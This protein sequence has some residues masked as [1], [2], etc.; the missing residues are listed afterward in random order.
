MGTQH[1]GPRFRPYF[2]LRLVP[3]QPSYPSTMGDSINGLVVLISGASS[4]IG[5]NCAMEFAKWGAKLA[6]TGR[7]A[8]RLEASAKRCQDLGL[9]KKNIYTITG[10]VTVKEDVQRIMDSVISHYGKLDVLVNNAGA[11]RARN[12]DTCEIEDLD[13]C[14]N[15]LV[16]SV[17]MMSKAAIPHLEKTKGAIINMSSLAGTR[18]LHYA[19][20][21]SMCKNM[22][23]R[24]TQILATAVGPRGIRV[25]TV[26]PAT[27][28]TE[29]F[30]KPDGPGGSAEKKKAY[31][32]WCVKAIPMGRIGEVEEVAR[33]VAFLCST[34]AN[35][36]NGCNFPID[37]SYSNTS[38]IPKLG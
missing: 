34:E 38:Y 19:V 12:I 1:F 25:N 8:E 27:V 18:P 4:G 24:F 2:F 30:D 15:V 16:R 26:N 13:W 32:D 36:L 20:P 22:V 10:D 29:M 7:N 11:T 23:D 31:L 3:R 5:M 6:L 28:K 35:Y 37:G 9:S 21:Y 33:L 14:Y 17:F